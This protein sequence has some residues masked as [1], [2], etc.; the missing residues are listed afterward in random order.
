MLNTTREIVFIWSRF[1][2][3]NIWPPPIFASSSLSKVACI[4]M[5]R[6]ITLQ[7]TMVKFCLHINISV[8]IA[9]YKVHVFQYWKKE[10]TSFQ[11]L[12]M[13]RIQH[14]ALSKI[15][16]N[17]GTSHIYPGKKVSEARVTPL[18]YSR[19]L[20]HWTCIL[21]GNFSIDLLELYWK[22]SCHVFTSEPTYI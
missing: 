8:L 16:P 15:R 21:T 1:K 6:F 3:K 19:H 17:T 14:R 2:T 12:L 10:L 13:Q 4:Q 18:C 20:R 11:N 9:L 7:G 5:L 22:H